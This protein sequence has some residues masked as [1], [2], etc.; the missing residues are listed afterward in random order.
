M[1]LCVLIFKNK[2]PVLRTAGEKEG[3][4]VVL[5]RLLPTIPE[6]PVSA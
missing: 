2:K 5:L 4:S 3:L 1:W 6:I